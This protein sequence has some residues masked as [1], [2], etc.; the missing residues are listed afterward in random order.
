MA[1]SRRAVVLLALLACVSACRTVPKWNERL[2][3]GIEGGGYRFENI[4]SRG[5]SDSL[6]VIL[7]FSGGGTRAASLA[8]GVL[9][10][11]ADTTIEWEGRRCRL[12]DEVDVISSVSGAAS[13]RPISGSTATAR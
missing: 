12:L 5:N 10:K 8:F 9:E 6:F 13:R 3:N 1:H 4:D 7:T 11:L 2:P